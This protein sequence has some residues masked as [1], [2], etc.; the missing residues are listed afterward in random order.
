MKRSVF[1]V[2]TFLMAA[3]VITGAPVMPAQA[4]SKPTAVEQL[5][6]ELAKLSP[7]ERAKRIEDGA[8]KEGKLVFVHTWR[9]K[10]A[11]DHIALFA[12]RYP[13][14]KVDMT[15]IGSQD[16]SERLVA[17]ET[18]GRHLTDVVSLAVP[19]LAEIL[20]ADLLANYPT[21]A[22][23][24]I[25][26]QYKGFLDPEHRWTPW[27][28]SEHGVSYNNSLVKPEQAPKAWKDLCNPAFRNS[29]SFDPAETRFMV[30]LYAI[31]G[32]Q[33]TEA[34][35]KC[36]GENKPI[37]QRGHTQRMELMLA[38]DHMV[39][40]DNYLYR[41]IEIQRETPATPYAIAYTAPVMGYA[42]VM[43]INKNTPHPY[44]AALLSDWSLSKE[45]QEYTA[46]NLRGPVGVKHPYLP[47]ET[48]VVT[49]GDVAPEIVDRLQ[50]YWTK[51]IGRGK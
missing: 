16:A 31:M 29:V 20:K 8:R 9:G 36:I 23:E 7:E 24:A 12:K 6:A 49:Y 38:G 2:A 51:Y 28:W 22:T 45:S 15:D 21:P 43:A 47:E 42:G 33:E 41:G 4:Q 26:A 37:I 32:E 3:A 46:K 40:G 30:G 48:K 17:E 39:Q 34:L 13:F 14:V 10:L 44:A 1:G 18:A 50:G 5:Y 35:L 27:Y 19:D 25:L 11:R